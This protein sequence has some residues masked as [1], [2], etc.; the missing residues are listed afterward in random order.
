MAGGASLIHRS[1][2]T[3]T[4]RAVDLRKEL[5]KQKGERA[6][7]WSQ[8]LKG[9]LERRIREAPVRGARRWPRFLEWRMLPPC[10]E[11]GDKLKVRREG[12]EEGG[13]REGRTAT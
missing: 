4:A 8:R 11:P 5:R 6:K 1:S 7:S 2:G 10:I 12:W 3:A 9:D 13:G